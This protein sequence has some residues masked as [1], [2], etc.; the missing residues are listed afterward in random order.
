MSKKVL[1]SQRM[2]KRFEEQI[3]IGE[4]AL[5]EIVRRGAQVMIQHA[6]ELEMTEF[7][8]R[9]HYKNDPEVTAKRGVMA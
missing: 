4:L 9:E 2:F 8:G 1:P 3:V 7:L 5:P 6:I